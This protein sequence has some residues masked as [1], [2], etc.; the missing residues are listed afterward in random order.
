MRTAKCNM[1]PGQTRTRR[2]HRVRSRTRDQTR[3]A[4]QRRTK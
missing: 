4:S 3:N 1:P 2:K